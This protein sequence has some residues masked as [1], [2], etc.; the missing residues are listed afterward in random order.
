MDPPDRPRRP[1][2][3]ITWRMRWYWFKNWF[4]TPLRL[5][6]SIVRLRH[7]YK[8][9]YLALLRMFVPFPS[10]YFPLPSRVPPSQ[11][12]QNE[13]L[14]YARSANHS[15]LRNVELW[16]LRDT[17][18]R[19]VYRMYEILMMGDYAP[20]GSETEYCWRHYEK[21]WTLSSIPDPKD[22]DPVRYAIVACIVEE[23]VNSFNWRL[24]LGM[25]RNGENIRRQKNGDPWP[26]YT[27]VV[28]PDWTRSVPPIEPFMLQD[29]PS[30]M[31]SESG[32][33]ILEERGC[34]E[35]F[36]KRNIVT[37]VGW[38]YTV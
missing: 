6:G 18:I 4:G 11:I 14:Y 15:T 7:I 34:D 35:G 17:P 37:N 2:P 25:R 27:P 19:C 5:R 38:W 30:D 3:K 20:L 26:P 32:K 23:L 24:A 13:N 16:A 12:A 29:L 22:P 8:H 9:P 28:G 10:W 33:L 36:A 21:N 1:R 31:V